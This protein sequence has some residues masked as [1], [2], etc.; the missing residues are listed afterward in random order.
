M[1]P[2]KTSQKD[3]FFRFEKCLIVLKYKYT[4]TFLFSRYNL[5]YIPVS[6]VYNDNLQTPPHFSSLFPLQYVSHSVLFTSGYFLKSKFA[7][8]PQ[9]HSSAY[10]NE[11]VYIGKLK[12]THW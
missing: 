3:T 4:L 1:Y 9:K 7:L 2:N 8:L 5:K 12:R 10:Y 6:I 11:N